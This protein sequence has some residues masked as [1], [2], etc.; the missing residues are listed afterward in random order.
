MEAKTFKKV[1]KVLRRLNQEA[2]KGTVTVTRF[3]NYIEG[4]GHLTEEL[5]MDFTKHST[6][7]LY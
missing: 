6:D 2:Y 1:K 7:W 3:L 4:E 5:T